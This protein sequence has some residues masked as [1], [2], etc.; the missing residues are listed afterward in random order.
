MADEAFVDSRSLRPA[1]ARTRPGG[2]ILP[3]S[4]DALSRVLPVGI[5]SLVVAALWIG[6][7]SG[8][9]PAFG[10]TAAFLFLAVEQDVRRMRIPNWLTLSSL[11]I[12]LALGAYQGGL[13]GFGE[14]LLGAGVALA[15]L[16]LPFAV[17]ALGA[18]DVKAAM[19]LGALWTTE[20]FLPALWW[21]VVA[22]GVMAIVMVAARGQLFDMLRRWGRSAVLTVRAARLTYISPADGSAGTGLPFAVAMGLG[23]AAYQIWGTPWV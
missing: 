12:A 20:T 15:I 6:A 9:L 21:M 10:W 13:D 22:G 5:A 8:R 23:A 16:F 1:D 14:A 7:A 4:P 2:G 3:A 17:R 19:V 11:L 18:G